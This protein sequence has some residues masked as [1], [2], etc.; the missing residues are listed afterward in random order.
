M[1]E[2]GKVWESR[3]GG[4]AVMH[5][6]TKKRLRWKLPRWVGGGGGCKATDFY[7]K[8]EFMSHKY[9]YVS[10]D[11]LLSLGNSFLSRISLV[12]TDALKEQLF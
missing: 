6:G 12:S 5:Y 9:K 10:D 8:V 1:V 3:C 7:I 2:S 4:N 11:P